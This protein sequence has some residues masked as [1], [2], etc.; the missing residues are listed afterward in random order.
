MFK[1]LLTTVLAGL[2]ASMTVVGCGKKAVGGTAAFSQATPEIKQIWD[3]AA[4]DDKANDYVA[5]VTGYRSL[6]AQRANLTEDQLAA[7]NTAALAIN[8]RLNAAANTGDAA[9]KEASLKLGAMQMQ[10]R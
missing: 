8:Q 5:A 2:L 10:Q 6:M 3:K 4:A 1:N 9:A 7:V